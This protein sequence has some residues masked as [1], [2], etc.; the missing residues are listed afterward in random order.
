ASRASAA[1]AGSYAHPRERRFRLGEIARFLGGP[2]HART[3]PVEVGIRLDQ[4]VDQVIE[5]LAAG[6]GEVLAL[7]RVAPAEPLDDGRD[8]C[9]ENLDVPIREAVHRQSPSVGTAGSRP[10]PLARTP[11][12]KSFAAYSSECT[13]AAV[14]LP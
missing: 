9:R 6:D 2:V 1:R 10:S 12:L 14:S 13:F 4:V 8:L 11:R 5:R 7:V 3:L